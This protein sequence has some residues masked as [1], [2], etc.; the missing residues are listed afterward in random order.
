MKRPSYKKTYYN[1]VT[2]DNLDKIKTLLN[3]K[4][5]YDPATVARIQ[6]QEENDLPYLFLPVD[7]GDYIGRGNYGMVD[8]NL[9]KI[10]SIMP[11]WSGWFY[12]PIVILR[13]STHLTM[14]KLVD[15]K[16]FQEHE[17]EHLK[18]L[19]DYIDADPAYIRR[20]KEL[21][22]TGCT[23]KN[24]ARSIQFEIEK[25]FRMEAATLALDYR[26]GEKTVAIFADNAVYEIAVDTEEE[27]L[28]YQLG[29]YLSRLIERYLEKFPR[30]KELIKNVSIKELD[31]QGQALFGDDALRKI[32]L[33]MIELW[34]LRHNPQ[35]ATRH[36]Y[37]EF[38]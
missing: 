33:L 1:L 7:S 35:R 24:L 8:G 21:N 38:D 27:F 6:Y 28:R 22:V 18:Q 13:R 23:L 10:E 26:N 37:G 30:H 29:K 34:D 36:E 3:K 17:L 15:Q 2:P 11:Q 19:L 32:A 14:Q 5:H 16:R 4:S 25:I 31:E 9:I 20:A 12:L